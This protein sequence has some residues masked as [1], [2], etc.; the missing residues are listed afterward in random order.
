MLPNEHV[1]STRV[2]ANVRRDPEYI[3]RKLPIIAFN[4]RA[5]PSIQKR[6]QVGKFSKAVH[7]I[8]WIHR[9]PNIRP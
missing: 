2:G 3:G 5:Q 8:Q 7:Q 4:N 6:T 9:Q 1:F